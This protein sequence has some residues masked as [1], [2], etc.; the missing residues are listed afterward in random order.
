VDKFTAVDQ[1]KANVAGKGLVVLTGRSHARGRQRAQAWRVVCFR[2]C[3]CAAVGGLH[4][5]GPNEAVIAPTVEGWLRWRMPSVTSSL[6]QRSENA[7][8]S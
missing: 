8:G 4:L 7:M 3:Y 5:S 2:A 1:L 6:H